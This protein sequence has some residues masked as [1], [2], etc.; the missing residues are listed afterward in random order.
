MDASR[1]GFI[2]TRTLRHRRQK[3]EP[4][5][6]DEGD[7]LYRLS[8]IVVLAEDVFVNQE[9]AARW[10]SK[11]RRALDGQSAFD[12]IKTTPGFLAVEELLEQLRYGY[13]S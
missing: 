8:R 10:L 11:P 12:A 13:V 7:R 4:L 3:S 2:N 1:L 5:S 9:K 6:C